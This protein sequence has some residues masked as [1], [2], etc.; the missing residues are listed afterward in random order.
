MSDQD[1]SEKSHEPS[2]KK[3]DDARKKGEIPKSTDLTTAAG[4]AG[5]VLVA[6]GFGADSLQRTPERRAP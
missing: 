6:V 5:M 4:Y 1:E 2:Q 3:L